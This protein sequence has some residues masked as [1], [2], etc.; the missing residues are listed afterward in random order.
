[1][2]NVDV[3]RVAIEISRL[4]GST[5][6]HQEAVDAAAHLITRAHEA[7]QREFA[8]SKSPPGVTRDE[9]EKHLR[10]REE[11]LAVP[12]DQLCRPP[13]DEEAVGS[14]ALPAFSEFTYRDERGEQG[15]IRWRVYRDAREFKE[16]IRKQAYGIYE[17]AA[18]VLKGLF[19]QSSWTPE[20]PGEL[21]PAIVMAIRF[22]R[23]NSYWLPSEHHE[24]LSTLKSLEQG[25][26][27]LKEYCDAAVDAYVKAKWE[28]AQAGQLSLMEVRKLHLARELAF[29]SRGRKRKK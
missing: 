14:G 8:R 23:E 27:F 13:T 1:M 26:R 6:V 10:E 25:K 7:R 4:G 21:P 2:Q 18:A 17:E 29:K 9:L 16:L 28:R 12:I 24:K 20:K 22:L 5:V 19:S 3:A 15:N 11:R